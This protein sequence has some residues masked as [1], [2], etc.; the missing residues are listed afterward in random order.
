ML[1]NLYYNLVRYANF[2]H[3]GYMEE[4]ASIDT[5]KRLWSMN[6]VEGD[7][8][9]TFEKLEDTEASIQDAEQF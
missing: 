8:R 5:F 6:P 4:V 1:N 2:K 3:S 9:I 7:S